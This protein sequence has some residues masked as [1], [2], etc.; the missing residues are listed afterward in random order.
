MTVTND[1]LIMLTDAYKNKR[2]R[3]KEAQKAELEV[4]TS[5]EKYS[6][7]HAI[8]E[9]RRTRGLT[10]SEIGTIIGIQN[11]TFIYDMITTYRRLNNG[12]ED[13]L[14][15]TITTN[16]DDTIKEVTE[17][18]YRLEFDDDAEA[19]SVIFPDDETY[20][21]LIEN[22]RPVDIPEEWEEHTRERRLI[23]KDILAE[24]RAHFKGSK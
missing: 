11:R 16:P 4:L 9:A 17:A 6:L 18:P 1:Q 20:I 2:Q 24:I 3:A 7:G 22:G 21:V 14:P 10:I 12:E 8:E 23:Y 19:V 15:D 5:P 13:F